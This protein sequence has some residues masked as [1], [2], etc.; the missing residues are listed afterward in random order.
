MRRFVLLT[1]LLVGCHS[2]SPDTTTPKEPREQP[3]SVKLD[4]GTGAFW[5]ARYQ[6]ETYIYGTKP[7]RFLTQTL[8][9][10]APGRILFPGEGEGRNAVWAAEQGWS[11]DAYDLSAEGKKKAELLATKRGVSINYWVDDFTAPK[12]DDEAYD[13]IAIIF[14][15]VPNDLLDKGL[16]AAYRALKPGGLLLI[17]VFADGHPALGSKFGPKNADVLY[18]EA[19][20]NAALQRFA[21]GKT[22]EIGEVNIELDEGFH[23]GPARVVRVAVEK[24]AILDKSP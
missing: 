5:D 6:G 8:A 20:M 1:L 23:Q 2:A 7:N 12:I 3:E 10:R 19:E 22:L 14:L 4:P 11:V 24:P 21:W 17:E 9:D 15:H 13:V 18:T 16:A